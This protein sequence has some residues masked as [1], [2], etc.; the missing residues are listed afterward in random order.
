MY[1]TI[2]TACFRIRNIFEKIKKALHIYKRQLLVLCVSRVLLYSE[3]KCALVGGLCTVFFFS[4]RSN[5]TM[6]MDMM[7]LYPCAPEVKA[8]G[9]LC[10]FRSFRNLH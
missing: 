5:F 2:I 4:N 10:S 3:Q 8:L 7:I 6:M 1:Y 9:P